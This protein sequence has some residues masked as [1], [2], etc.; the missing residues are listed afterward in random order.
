VLPLAALKIIEEASNTPEEL[1]TNYAIVDECSSIS[2]LTKHWAQFQ[3][4]LQFFV[5][6]DSRK[7]RWVRRCCWNLSVRCRK[8]AWCD[9]GYSDWTLTWHICVSKAIKIFTYS[10]NQ[11][12][13]CYYARLTALHIHAYPLTIDIVDWGICPALSM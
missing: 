13:L 9:Q 1:Q 2:I 7:Q 10:E 6:W 12:I 8:S 3:K 5:I 4:P 11:R